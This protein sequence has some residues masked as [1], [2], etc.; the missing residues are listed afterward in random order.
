MILILLIENGH[1]TNKVNWSQCY[2]R[3]KQNVK[4][5]NSEKIKKIEQT[6]FTG[7]ALKK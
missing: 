4:A 5:E 3:S 1:K 7:D 2:K 6:H